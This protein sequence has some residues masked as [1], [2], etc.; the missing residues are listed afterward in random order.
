MSNRFKCPRIWRKL[1]RAESN[2][3]SRLWRGEGAAPGE[4]VAELLACNRGYGYCLRLC[5][6]DQIAVERQ[7][8]EASV[9]VGDAVDHD[10]VMVQAVLIVGVDSYPLEL[11]VFRQD[12]KPLCTP[13]EMLEFNL[14]RED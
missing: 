6:P 3:V 5:R 8:H 9:F 7:G 12:G 10:H 2:L 13:L 14:V 4:A 1:S 11:E